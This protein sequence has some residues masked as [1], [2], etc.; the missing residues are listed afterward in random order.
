MKTY[1]SSAARVVLPSQFHSPAK[2][3]SRPMARAVWLAALG[4]LS[5]LLFGAAGG[6][7]GG[8]GGGNTGGGATANQVAITGATPNYVANTLTIRGTNFGTSS[9]SGTVTLSG[10]AG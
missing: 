7:S 10:P 4:A 2:R 3:S 5:P 8:S 6:G 1:P 9:F